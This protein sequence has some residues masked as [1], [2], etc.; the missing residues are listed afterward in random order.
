MKPLKNIVCATDFS[1]NSN[2]ALNYASKLAKTFGAELVLI[3]VIEDVLEAAAS[4]PF[5]YAGIEGFDRQLIQLK[6]KINDEL[7]KK[8]EELNKMGVKTSYLVLEGNPV[9]ELIE[10][11][12]DHPCD[13]IVMGTYGRTGLPHLLIGSVAEKVVRKAPCAVLTVRGKQRSA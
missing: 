6:A 12:A 11:P 2:E 10:Y 7:Q 3:H 9:A 8:S 4:V 1:D 5:T 13:L